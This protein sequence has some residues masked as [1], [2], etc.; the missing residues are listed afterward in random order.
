MTVYIIVLSP[1]KAVVSSP[2]IHLLLSA[3]HPGTQE[4]IAAVLLFRL[5]CRF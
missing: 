1:P 2:L 5:V 3:P 4:M